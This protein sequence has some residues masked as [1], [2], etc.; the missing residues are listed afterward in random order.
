MFVQISSADGSV[1]AINSDLIA[2]VQIEP[3]R[4][5][6]ADEDP[7]PP[8][9]TVEM[10]GMQRPLVYRYTGLQSV[11]FLQWWQFRADVYAV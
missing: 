10:A 4:E 8:T 5:V 3:E 6:A 1:H 9:V 2:S 11:A 7:V